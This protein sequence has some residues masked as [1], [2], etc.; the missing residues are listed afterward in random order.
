MNERLLQTIG[1]ELLAWPGVSEVPGRFNSIE[2]RYGKAEIGHIHRNGVAD[3]P[4]TRALHDDL[5]AAGRAHPHQAGS[6]GY[7]SVPIRRESDVPAAVDLFR[8]NYERA[9]ESAQRRARASA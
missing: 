6:A 1:R 8:M 7:V 3:L 2:Y 4:F 5:I 9:R